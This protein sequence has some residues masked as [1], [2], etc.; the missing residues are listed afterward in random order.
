LGLLVHPG[1][2]VGTGGA[3]LPDVVR[4]L[5]G[6]VA[7]LERAPSQI[8]V[9]R[10]RMR[11]IHELEDELAARAEALGNAPWPQSLVDAFWLI[12]ELRLVQLAPGVAARGGASAK[13]V[14]KLLSGG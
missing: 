11:A 7:R 12:Q 2:I 8:G 14:R 4:Y 13:K 3:R 10:D 5:Q 6:H 1:W 9:D